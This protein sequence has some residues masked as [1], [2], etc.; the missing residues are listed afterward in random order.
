MSHI[1][2][3]DFDLPEAKGY[4]CEDVLKEDSGWIVY[5]DLETAIND[6]L[7]NEVFLNNTNDSKVLYL[8]AF[9]KSPTEDD[10]K[11]L[12]TVRVE[13]SLNIKLINENEG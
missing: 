4:G 3:I 5:V 13:V 8:G 9:D 6:F 1:K 2:P 12:K 10:P 11:L 7:L